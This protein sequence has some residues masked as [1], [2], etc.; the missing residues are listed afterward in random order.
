MSVRII[1][2]VT[3][4]KLLA[5]PASV[6]PVDSTWYMPN[7]PHNAREQFRQNRIKNA[8]F[9]DLDKVS[10]QPSKYPH[11][12]PAQRI[13][14]Q[15]VSSM[16]ISTSDSVMVYD[17]T[18]IFSGPR[19]AWTFAL[20]GHKDV[21]LVDHYPDFQRAFPDHV[22]GEAPVEQPPLQYG[23]ISVDAFSKK[24]RE[25]VIEFEELADLVESGELTSN[26]VMFDARSAGRFSG[27]EPEPRAGLPAGHVPGSLSL[28]FSK[29]LT[30]N[31]NYKTKE[32]I[33]SLLQQ[34]F[35]L[36]LT[37]PFDKGI[38]V[39]CGTGVTAVILKLAIELVAPNIPLRV[40]DGSWTEWAQRA[41]HLVETA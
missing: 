7:N 37:A 22:T 13:F 9:F 28:P 1:S 39:L 3:A 35:G 21:Y 4:A 25:Q 20:Y 16:G 2:P 27:E 15:A 33:S 31:G 26:Y 41:P 29:V 10:L 5:S 6:V 24:Y 14:N 34:E 40:Y 11:M 19:A 23:G 32:E 18:G 36:D 12:L 38:I 30:E 8:V 17:R